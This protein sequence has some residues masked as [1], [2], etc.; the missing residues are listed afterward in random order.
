MSPEYQTVCRVGLSM[1]LTP[2]RQ[3]RWGTDLRKSSDTAF[4][5]EV[6]IEVAR[7]RSSRK[8]FRNSLRDSRPPVTDACEIA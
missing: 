2:E 8:R 4:K 6:A 3:G 5:V 7:W 1:I